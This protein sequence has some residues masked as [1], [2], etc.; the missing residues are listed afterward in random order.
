VVAESWWSPWG[1]SIA[2]YAILLRLLVDG[3]MGA[4]EFEVVFLRLYKAD[5]TAW[6]PAV[7]DVFDRLFGDVDAFCL[8]PALRHQTQGLDED[9]LRERGRVALKLL[10]DVRS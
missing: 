1:P 4:E 2:P 8:D 7:F 5:P 3:R 9:Q 10:E 6:P